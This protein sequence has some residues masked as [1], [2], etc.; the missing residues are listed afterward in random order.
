MLPAHRETGKAFNKAKTKDGEKVK[1]G[2]AFP[3]CISVNKCVRA[4]SCEALLFP[5]LM[6]TEAN[7]RSLC[8]PVKRLTRTLRWRCPLPVLQLRVSLVQQRG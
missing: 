3:T 6:Q 4:C 7:S 2:S 5:S 1:K 8:A